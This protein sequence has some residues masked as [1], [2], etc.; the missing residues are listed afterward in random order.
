MVV[1]IYLYITTPRV[2][3]YLPGSLFPPMIIV[4]YD[5]PQMDDLYITSHYLDKC[6]STSVAYLKLNEAQYTRASS[7]QSIYMT[8]CII[9]LHQFA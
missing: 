9:K 6:V 2:C 5:K 3:V 7:E 8:G 4:I 1:F